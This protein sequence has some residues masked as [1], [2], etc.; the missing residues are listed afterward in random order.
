MVPLA[1]LLRTSQYVDGRARGG[2]RTRNRGLETHFALENAAI[3]DPAKVVRTALENAVSVASVLLLTEATM[4]ERPEKTKELRRQNRRYSHPPSPLRSTEHS[5][6]NGR[7]YYEGQRDD[8]REREVPSVRSHSIT[9]VSA[10]TGPRG[11]N[12]WDS[13]DDGA[14]GKE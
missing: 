12:D 11:R 1:M 13:A 10:G 6:R 7:D 4:T 5:C 3:V 14:A 8:Y 2:N 9:P